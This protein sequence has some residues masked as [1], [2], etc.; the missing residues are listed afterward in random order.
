MQNIVMNRSKTSF[1]HLGCHFKTVG[2][3]QKNLKKIFFRVK[4]WP[5]WPKNV[6]FWTFW[7]W[8]CWFFRGKQTKRQNFFFKMSQI[9]K[10]LLKKN[11]RSFG[12]KLAEK[13]E[14][15]NPPP[16]ELSRGGGVLWIQPLSEILTWHDMNP[17]FVWFFIFF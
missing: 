11:L 6:I 12:K 13:I 10:S 3:K 14:K 4:I 9:Y 2:W 15:K 1:L 7:F 16:G 8:F 17:I 5:F